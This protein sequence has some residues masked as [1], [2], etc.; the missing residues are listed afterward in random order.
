MNAF[1]KITL[2][3][4]QR[5]MGEA[6]SSHHRAVWTYLAIFVPLTSFANWLDLR[7]GLIDVE[8]ANSVGG[9]IFNNDNGLVGLIALLLSIAGQYL[10]IERMTHAPVNP[11]SRPGRILGFVGLAIVSFLGVALATVLLIF[12]GLFLG[13]RWLMSPV[14]YIDERMWVFGALG[15]SWRHTAGNTGIVML[16]LFLLLFGTLVVAGTVGGIVGAVFG[17]IGFDG[18]GFVIISGLA[19]ELWSV[20]LIALAVGVYRLLGASSS[21]LAETFS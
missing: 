11:D 15:A 6:I 16:A 7:M 19:G 5:E 21:E 20:I 18:L 1:R 4:I 13:A 10:L 17:S 14:F 3:D 12:P 9:I 8:E 2:A